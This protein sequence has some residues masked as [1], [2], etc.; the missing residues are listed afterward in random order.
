M[1]KM[2][3]SGVLKRE[4]QKSSFYCETSVCATFFTEELIELPFSKFD[5]EEKIIFKTSA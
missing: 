4:E 1:G 2:R 5:R 3:S